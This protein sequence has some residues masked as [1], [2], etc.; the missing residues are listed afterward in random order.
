MR[1]QWLVTNALS[2]IPE[3]F[4]FVIDF[5][6]SLY[7]H[8]EGPGILTGMSNPEQPYGE[9]QRIDPDW[10]MRH[11]KVAVGR[12]PLLAEAGSASGRQDSTK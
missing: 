11:I 9:D 10:E 4:P 12:M 8:R 2:G 7:F 5:A 1:R 6:A 3:E